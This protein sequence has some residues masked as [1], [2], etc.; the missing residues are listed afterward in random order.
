MM[1]ILAALIFLLQDGDV[2]RIMLRFQQRRP[3]AA[4]SPAAFD[5]LLE[6]TRAQLETFVKEH[7]TH[8]DA[9]RAAYHAAETYVWGRHFPKAAEKL[10]ALLKDYSEFDLAPAARFAL[11]EVL[12]QADQDARARQAFQD[13]LRLHPGDERAFFARCFVAI[14]L[15]NERRYEEAEAALKEAREKFKDRKES[16]QAIMQLAIVYHVQGRNEEARRALEELIRNCPERAAV[17]IARRHLSEYL[18][19]GQDAPAFGEKDAFGAD[20]AL[21]RGKVTVLYFFDPYSPAA[22]MEALFLRRTAEALKSKDLRYM[23]VGVGLDKQEFQI[24]KG[25]LKLEWP[26][27]FDGKAFDGKIARLYDVR[28]LPALTVIDRKGKVRYFNIAGRDLRN[29]LERLLEEK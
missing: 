28:G 12:L 21:E 20:F 19:V 6:Q 22:E 25:A 13:Y 4:D 3:L 23:G 8:R 14:T 27:H 7:P 16:W 29:A 5:R 18:K 24:F 2:D 9:P 10:E 1:S 15:Q 26:L 17:E 11:G